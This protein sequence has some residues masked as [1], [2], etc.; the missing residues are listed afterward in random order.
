MLCGS[1]RVCLLCC[2]LICIRLVLVLGRI[3]GLNVFI[4]SVVICDCRCVC[5]VLM[6]LLGLY[7]SMWVLVRL[8]SVLNV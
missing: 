8:F 2:S 1:V 6:K 5:V 7:I 3:G 4:C